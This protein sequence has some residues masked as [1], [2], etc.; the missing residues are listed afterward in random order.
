MNHHPKAEAWFR[1]AAQAVL[2]KAQVPDLYGTVHPGQVAASL[3]YSGTLGRVIALPGLNIDGQLIDTRPTHYLAKYLPRWEQARDYIAS[4]FT[5]AGFPAPRMTR[6]DLGLI[7][8]VP[9]HL[10]TPATVHLDRVAPGR[11]TARIAGHPE[12]VADIDGRLEVPTSQ[13]FILSSSAGKHR[14][15]FATEVEAA[16]AFAEDCGF[17]PHITVTT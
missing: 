12:L 2:D 16:R 13:G 3:M 1:Q 7:L 15:L 17:G 4:L 11:Y 10:G 9:E 6:L 8:E 14:G 5:E